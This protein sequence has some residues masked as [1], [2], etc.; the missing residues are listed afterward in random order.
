VNFS[1]FHILQKMFSSKRGSATRSNLHLVQYDHPEKETRTVTDLVTFHMRDGKLVPDAR[2]LVPSEDGQQYLFQCCP[3]NLKDRQKALIIDFKILYTLNDFD[4]PLQFAVETMFP[5]DEEVVEKVHR[6]D[7]VEEGEM[8]PDFTG[9]AIIHIP[10]SAMSGPVPKDAR[11][12][13]R[14]RYHDTNGGWNV[15]QYAGTEGHILHAKSTHI[16]VDEV[17]L[18]SQLIDPECQYLAFM[19]TDPFITFV[20]EH[21]HLFREERDD[22]IKMVANESK[23]GGQIYLVRRPF[24]ERIQRFFKNAV[25]PFFNYTENDAIRFAWKVYPKM[26]SKNL[27]PVVAF[28]VQLDYM[29][30]S[31]HVPRIEVNGIKLNI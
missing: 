26:H 6:D 16:M 10:P 2:H 29:V 1:R 14:P 12:I 4:T 27:D 7:V 13:Y 28:M 20:L 15:P 24:V 18:T 25:Y 17:S 11:I 21:H 8:H 3:L 9:N 31:P 5:V 22:D 19:Y 30:I 23:Q